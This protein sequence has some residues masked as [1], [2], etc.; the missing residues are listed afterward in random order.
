[1]ETCILCP[2]CEETEVEGPDVVCDKCAQL[3][4]ERAEH[5]DLINRSDW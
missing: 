3:F 4:A 1:M 2:F 5:T